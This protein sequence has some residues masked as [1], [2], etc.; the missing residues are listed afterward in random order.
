MRTGANIFDK[1]T[2]LL[3]KYVVQ[4]IINQIESNCLQQCKIILER[5]EI[6][7]KT[8]PGK[9]AY[10]Y[11]FETILQ[12]YTRKKYVFVISQFEQEYIDFQCL[13]IR[14]NYAEQIH[15]LSSKTK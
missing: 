2:F 4:K 6:S 1:I 14:L 7:A 12:K 11:F 3:G 5:S 9:N 15:I 13:F 10:D 8:V